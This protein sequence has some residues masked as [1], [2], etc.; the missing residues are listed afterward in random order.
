MIGGWAGKSGS[1]HQADRITS[2]LAC[3]NQ[4]PD[5]NLESVFSGAPTLRSAR[6][7]CGWV[8]ALRHPGN[9]PWTGGGQPTLRHRRQ[10][11]TW[12]SKFRGRRDRWEA[13]QIFQGQ[14]IARYAAQP[15]VARVGESRIRCSETGGHPSVTARGLRG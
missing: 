6:G 11:Q 13:P 2:R 14:D 5:A 12:Q 9:E 1:A 15:R 10:S 8:L 3:L 7:S 4:T